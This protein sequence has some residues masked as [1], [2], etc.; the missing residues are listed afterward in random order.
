MILN[1]E[2]LILEVFFKNPSKQYHIRSLARVTG[3]N[4]NTVISVT[5]RLEEDGLIVKERNEE[6]NMVFIKPLESRDFK[7]K[8]IFYNVN[9]LFNS[10]L[11]DY[12]NKELAF[13]TIMVFGSY[14]KG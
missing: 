3:L 1:K 5:D 12:L 11:V 2:D 8:K 6:T 9:A 4:P 10:G 13:P 7:I 14:S